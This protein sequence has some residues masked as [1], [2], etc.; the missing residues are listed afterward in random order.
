MLGRRRAIGG[1]ALVVALLAAAPASAQQVPSVVGPYDGTNPFRCQ[2]QN[3]GTGT[4]FPDP[5]ADPFCVE[6]D[7]TNQNVTGFGIADFAAQEPARLAAAGTKCF[8][9]QRDH[10][11][12]S[13]IQGQDPELWHWDG[14]Y[15]FDRARGVGG[16]SVRNFRIGGQPADA[17]PF[18]P[19][20]YRQYF[21]ADGGGGVEVVLATN[22][23]PIC[24]AK[25]DT[26]AERDRVYADRG[27]YPDCIEPDG[28]V[29]GR[30]VGRAALGRTRARTLVRLGPPKRADHGVDR[31]CLVGKGELRVAY[32]HGRVA[33]ILTSGRGQ[34]FHGV[35]RG[36]RVRRARKRLDLTGA[37]AVGHR[38]RLL[39]AAA[40]GGRF[41][42][43]GVSGHRVRW[44]T[45]LSP[46]HVGSARIAHLIRR[47]R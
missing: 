20:A 18:V 47:V 11:T 40:T 43:L 26:P 46:H 36:D 30:R 22:P 32:R 6:F 10:W 44:V 28:V 5:G 17:T 7:K 1:L 2:L 25:V 34:T 33:G 23:D 14:N 19:A 8:Y 13:L 24:G 31:W 35:G 4:D 27:V 3:V 12:G 37:V 15:W 29:R 42:G 38:T 9:F 41:V 39:T 45:V 21:D 16:V